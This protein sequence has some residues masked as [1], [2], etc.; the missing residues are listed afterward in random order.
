[1]NASRRKKSTL[2]LGHDAFL[3]IV[4]NL[5]GILIILVVVLGTQ[6]TAVIEEIQDQIEN[7]TVAEA[8]ASDEQLAELARQSMRAA[9]AQADSDRF[10]DLIKQFDSQIEE[11]KQQRGILMD[12]L[13]EAEAAWN[14]KKTDLDRQT[15]LAAQRYTE[16]TTA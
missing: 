7:E 3:D 4:A 14:E 6:S 12:L 15:T 5:V 16:F 2:E 8:Y 11:R 9:S 1:M 10:E 13:A